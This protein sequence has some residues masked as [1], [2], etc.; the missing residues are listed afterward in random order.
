LGEAIIGMIACDAGDARRIVG[1]LADAF[2]ITLRV[3]LRLLL[4][5]V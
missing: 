1:Q 5:R 2:R 4:S 3:A